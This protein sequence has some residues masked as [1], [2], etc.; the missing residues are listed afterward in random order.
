MGERESSVVIRFGPLL[1]T[2]S[3]MVV[4]KNA[5]HKLKKQEF[6]ILFIAMYD[7]TDLSCFSS[8]VGF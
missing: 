5:W 7:D 1:Y 3:L 8:S 6:C 4:D 2:H